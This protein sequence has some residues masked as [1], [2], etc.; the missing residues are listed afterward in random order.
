MIGFDFTGNTLVCFVI[1]KNPSMHTVINA[2]LLNLAISDIM[3][4]VVTVPAMLSMLVSP[5]YWPFGEAVCRTVPFF[6]TVTLSA[7]IYT[8]VALAIDR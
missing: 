5:R 6:S 8:M 1:I 7:S 2:F 4:I 3:F